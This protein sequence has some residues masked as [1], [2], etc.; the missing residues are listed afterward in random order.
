MYKE[1]L[2]PLDGSELAEQALPHAT[3][4]GKAFHSRVTLIRIIEPIAIFPEPGVVGPVIS[5]GMDIEQDMKDTEDYL[6]QISNR[7]IFEGVDAR[8]VIRE[9][10]AA[11][12]ICQYAQESNTNL[13]VMTTHGRSGL[14][15]LFYGSV[16]ESVLHSA[17]MPIL[18]VRILGEEL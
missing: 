15:R 14:Q 5:I 17:K 9:G 1:I 13:V 2:V 18:L 4:I 16:A 11:A 3:E 12:Q 7:L 10:D 8:T 6:K